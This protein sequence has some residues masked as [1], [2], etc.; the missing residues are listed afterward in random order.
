MR[1]RFQGVLTGALRG[2]AA[3]L[4]AGAAWWA[5]EGAIN[6]LAG[7]VVPALV[8]G[9]L[10]ALDVGLG[11]VF[12]LVIGGAL[13]FGGRRPGGAALAL[14]LAAA[15]GLLRVWEP[16][17]LG[18]EA[19]F[20]AASATLA[21]LALALGGRD[22]DGGLR[23]LHVTL[24]ATAAVG[25]GELLL[26]GHDAPLTGIRLPLV[27]AA[28]PLA[29]LVADALVGLVVRRHGA[30][31]ALELVAAGVAA[32][33]LGHPLGSAP[34]DDPIVTAV[35]PPAGTPDVILVSLDTTRADH[36][37]T[38]GYARETSPH[39]TAF[40]ADALRFT[41]ARSPAAWTL[42]GHASLFTGMYPSRHGARL[43]GA[44]LPGESIDGRRR[45]AFPLAPSAV[46][47]AEVLRD[48]GY[49]TGAF[50][51]NFSYLYRDWGLAQGFAR[52]DDAPGLLLRL[53]P[54]AMRFARHFAPGF[55]LKPFRAAPEINAAA[56]TWLDQAP[57]GRPVLLFVNYMEPH[58]PWL[59]PAPYDGW[60]RGLPD[61]T[62]LA[63]KNLYTHEV[64]DLRES[65]RAFITANYDGQLAAM[66]AALGELLDALRA[67]GRYENALVIVTADHGEFLGEHGQVGH[68]GRM[69]Y[70][71][72]LHVPLVVKL[73][74]ADHRRGVVE[75]PVQL[76]DVLPTV[77]EATGATLPAGVQGEPLLA[78]THASLAEEEINPFLVSHYGE[79]YNRGVRVLY[80][81][82]YKL[83]STTRGER[84]LFD[85]AH[86][87]EE[88]HDLAEREPE[89]T[90]SLLRRLHE[91]L[92]TPVGTAQAVAENRI[93]VK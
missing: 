18:A 72:V 77:V 29:G 33:V 87:P 54:H 20:L 53:S 55:L 39:L 60:A 63:E 30:R 4:V 2:L 24:L 64:R 34:L 86:D 10:A 74:G 32:L 17:G 83:I 82:D 38:Y 46:T 35:P 68:I 22:R 16:P 49:Q 3:G 61:A 92:D 81:G 62:R 65:E 14:G 57:A 79:T 9:Q 13:G 73:P 1:E 50:V 80:D 59:A 76:V 21:P 7:A 78:V 84:M 11:A 41:E 6:W 23:F 90:T 85:L 66:D 36:L 70:E 37:S 48:R 25:L 28:L 27:I 40:A 69:L 58:Q 93:E 88:V 56:L 52:Y 91:A 44:W 26:E 42:P 8:L 67:R 47:L 15:Y 12:G 71:P 5:V 31:L 45:V 75:T 43:A 89:R 51:A 19:L